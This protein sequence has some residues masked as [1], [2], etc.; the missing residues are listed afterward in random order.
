MDALLLALLLTA[1][2]DQGSGT[3]HLVSQMSERDGGSDGRRIGAPVPA[4][5][6]VIAV[7][8]ILAA[9]LG[10]IM[11]TWLMPDARL[12]FF[13]IALAF[14]AVGHLSASFRRPPPPPPERGLS[15]TLFGY[16]LRRAGEN[17]AFVTA[18][19]VTFTDAP[20]LAII[21][22]TIGGW[23]A[24]IPT[25]VL[26]ERYMRHRLTRAAL[27]LSGAILLCVAIGCAAN[28]LRIA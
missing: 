6:L 16:A 27:L 9:A 15:R 11:A 3:Q 19:I 24:L 26:G 23:L 7:N 2:L 14:G 1:L 4:L 18:A 17:S 12:L 22:A 28:A 25:L 20:L 21:G 10:A 5:F 13:A 8:A